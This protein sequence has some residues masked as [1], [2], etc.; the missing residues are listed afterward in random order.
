LE[1]Q[2][3]IQGQRALAGEFLKEGAV[4]FGERLALDRGTR[5]AAR[6]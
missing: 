5:S 1:K 4:C 3:S 2:C 6:R